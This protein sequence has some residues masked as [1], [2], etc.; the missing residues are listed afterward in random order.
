MRS[1]GILVDLETLMLDDC[2][3]KCLVTYRYL[4]Q[5]ICQ[6]VVAHNT[7]AIAMLVCVKFHELSC[8]WP[9][10]MCNLKKILNLNW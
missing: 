1:Y 10:S 5:I 6:L 9:Q 7:I 4:S 8:E 3:T 2:A